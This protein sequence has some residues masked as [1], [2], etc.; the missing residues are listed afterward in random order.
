MPRA[1]YVCIVGIILRS[2]Q[3]VLTLHAS[4]VDKV[5]FFRGRCG[6]LSV[7]ACYQLRVV[8]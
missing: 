4:L 2:V 6:S 3:V 1:A 7:P 5:P 8:L